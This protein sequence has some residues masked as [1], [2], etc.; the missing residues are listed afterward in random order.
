[1]APAR[2]G[3]E[4][5][6]GQEEN[7]EEREVESA[8]I[9]SHKGRLRIHFMLNDLCNGKRRADERALTD[10]LSHLDLIFTGVCFIL[11]I[12][13]HHHQKVDYL[14]QAHVGKSLI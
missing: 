12:P 7:D 3:H 5:K 6:D 9:D 8:E 11:R 10:Q 1:M 4:D 14:N 2:P 13:N